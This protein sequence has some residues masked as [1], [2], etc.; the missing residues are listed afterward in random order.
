MQKLLLTISAVAIFSSA[1]AQCNDLFIS[2]YV[3]GWSNNKAIEIY[4][5]TGSPFDMS[6]YSLVR[7]Q[8]QDDMPGNQT[9]LSGML[10]AHSTYV[11]V[12]DKRDTLGTGFEAPVWDELQAKADVFVNPLYN[13]GAEVMYF[14][15]NDPVSL[16]KNN[17][18]AIVDIF[19][20]V[21]DLANPDG[22]GP[23]GAGL[24]MSKDHTLI[25]KSSVQ[26]G[27]LSSPTTFDVTLEWDS[28]SANT[29]D[30]LGSHTSSCISVGTKNITI[31][32]SK[33]WIYP[34]PSNNGVV[35]IR[36]NNDVNSIEVHNLIGQSIINED[37]RSVKVNRLSLNLN[38][39]MYFITANFANG[40]QTTKRIVIE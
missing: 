8:N 10:Q 32:P 26:Q 34:N 33:L 36:T 1:N 6:G 11:V 30:S 27:V 9:L 37:Y 24:F 2:E 22:W 5:P 20:K 4:N 38:P 17:G 14:N 15:G 21:K 31:K 39:G 16:L 29:F 28:L 12:I 40:A 7:F 19:G 18:L 3:E 13:N 23:F 35:Y 25:R